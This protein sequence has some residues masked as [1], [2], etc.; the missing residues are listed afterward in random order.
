MLYFYAS[1]KMYLN[2]SVY[3]NVLSLMRCISCIIIIFVLPLYY[4]Y[5]DLFYIKLCKLLHTL[6]PIKA[7]IKVLYKAC[8]YSVACF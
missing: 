6:C 7:F 4:V 3:A 1:I 2:A 5:Q 8:V